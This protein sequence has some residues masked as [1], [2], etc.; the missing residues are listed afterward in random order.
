MGRNRHTAA[1]G[2]DRQFEME[3][4]GGPSPLPDAA[5]E[6]RA[7]IA[8]AWGL[9]L[10][11][12]VEVCLRSHERAAVRG[13]LELAA[14]PGFPWRPQEPLRLRVTGFTFSSRDIERW[15]RL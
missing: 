8:A 3:L 4:G 9:P 12:N 2:D 6:I 1:A 10:G 5:P 14:A 13:T 11:E 7:E 15:T